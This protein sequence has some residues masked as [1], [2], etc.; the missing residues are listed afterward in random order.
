MSEE[1]PYLMMLEKPKHY[2]IE[3]CSLT[4]QD[5]VAYLRQEIFD[6]LRENLERDVDYAYENNIE[7]NVDLPEVEEVAVAFANE[8]DAMAFKLAW[9]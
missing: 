9:L 6:W 4:G 8:E 3:I 2:H 1:F 5:F 7:T